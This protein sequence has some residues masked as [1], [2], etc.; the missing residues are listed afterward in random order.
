MHIE[1]RR[2]QDFRIA[3]VQ[4]QQ[5]EVLQSG[6]RFRHEALERARITAK[7]WDVPVIDKSGDQAM[8]IWP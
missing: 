4:E 3:L 2:D 7:F 6:I 8:G 5:R 1:I